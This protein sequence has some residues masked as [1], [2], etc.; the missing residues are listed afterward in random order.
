VDRRRGPLLRDL[1]LGGWDAE[2][3]PI[4]AGFADAFTPAGSASGFW[5]GIYKYHG[6]RGSGTVARVDGWIAKL[7]LRVRGGLNPLLGAAVEPPMPRTKPLEKFAATPWLDPGLWDPQQSETREP[8]PKSGIE[9]AAFPSGTTRTPFV[10]ELFGTSVDVSLVAGTVGVVRTPAG[11]IK[12]VVGWRVEGEGG[13]PPLKPPSPSS[14]GSRELGAIALE[15]EKQQPW[16]RGP[17][18]AYDAVAWEDEQPPQL[19]PRRTQRGGC[20]IS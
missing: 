6:P 1:G 10:W 15:K 19:A 7:F 3:Q 14:V 8:V 11:A 18:A 9:L 13:E 4:L 20:A 17:L 12:P 5:D 16:P 2:L